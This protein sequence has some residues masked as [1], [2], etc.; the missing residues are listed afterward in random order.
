MLHP[1]AIVTFD[2]GSRWRRHDVAACV[3][4][5]LALAIAAAAAPGGTCCCWLQGKRLR[6]K[7]GTPVEVWYGLSDRS[8]RACLQHT[9]AEQTRQ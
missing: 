5:L 2:R 8:R 4:N 6:G 7:L 3:I 9:A 1:L